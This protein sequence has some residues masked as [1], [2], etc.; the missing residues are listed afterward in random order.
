MA[1]KKS[2][3][4]ATEV[5]ERRILEGRGHHVMLDEHLAELYDVTVSAQV[6]PRQF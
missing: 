6:L 2:A 3:S 5:V 4:V 1:K